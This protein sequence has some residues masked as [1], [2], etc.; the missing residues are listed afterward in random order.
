M[1]S[2]LMAADAGIV[3]VA[4]L[5]LVLTT[6]RLSQNGFANIYY[7][8]GVKSMLHSLHDFF[9]VSFD[10]GGLVSV[11]KP[12]L[13]LWLQV[14]QREAVRLQTAQPA[15][16]GGDLRAGRGARACT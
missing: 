2:R 16:A 10:Q 13:G 14:R 8:A 6:H 3:L 15:A 5:W 7:S 1:R 4:A 9:Y 11:D 12:P